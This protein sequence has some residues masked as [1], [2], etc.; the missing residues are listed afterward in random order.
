MTPREVSESNP[1]TEICSA[2]GEPC[3]GI[4]M[5][6]GIGPYE[7]WGQRG[8]DSNPRYV[9]NCCEADVLMDGKV[10]EPQEEFQ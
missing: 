8:F 1:L 5:D 6:F 9:S 4:V 2:C 7:Y 10:Y 3:K